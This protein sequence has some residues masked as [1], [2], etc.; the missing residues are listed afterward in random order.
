MV[1][2]EIENHTTHTKGL[3]EVSSI[4]YAN[5]VL[6]VKGFNRLLN[7]VCWAGIN[8]KG[9]EISIMEPTYSDI[10]DV[11]PVSSENSKEAKV[12]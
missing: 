4:K 1:I 9:E 8:D 2:L 10:E 7:E 6:V 12:A 11:R 5:D 3:I